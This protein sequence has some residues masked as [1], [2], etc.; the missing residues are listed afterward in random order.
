MPEIRPDCP[1]NKVIF[2]FV[3]EV[4]TFVKKEVARVA[5]FHTVVKKRHGVTH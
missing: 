5:Y 2:Y 1:K 3:Y 4:C